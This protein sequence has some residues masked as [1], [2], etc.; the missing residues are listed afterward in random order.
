MRKILFILFI[1]AFTI[2]STCDPQ[3][4]EDVLNTVTG[5]T[6]TEAEAANGLKEALVQGATNGS[7]VLSLVNGY[8]GNPQVKIPFPPEAQKIESTLRDLGL[9][10]MCDD[11]I[12]SLNRAAE[13]AAVEAKAILIN[14]IRQ[15]TVADAMNILFGAN[16][17]ATEYLK[18]TTTNALTAKFQPVI[19]KSLAEVNATKYWSDAVNYYNAIPLVQDLNPDLSGYVTGKALDGL[20]YMIEQEELKIRENPG[21]RVAEI[22]KKVFGYYDANK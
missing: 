20:F 13:D 17:A 14:S 11:V 8:L 3:I 2:Q 12:N 9:N 4:M 10:K 16:D 6:I 21:E 19:D 22:V 1:S 5:T 15:M 7:D 18:K